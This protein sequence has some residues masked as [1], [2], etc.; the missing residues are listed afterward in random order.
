M[1][2]Y[3]LFAGVFSH[4]AVKGAL[5]DEAWLQALLDVEAGLARA[6]ARAGLA[7]PDAAEAVG[8]AAL[9]RNFSLAELGAAS[10]QAGNPIPALVKALRAA[11][12]ESARGA[13]HTGATSQDIVDSALM[14][15][16]RRAG[17]FVSRDLE[18]AAAAAAQLADRH[19]KT[20]MLGRTLLQQAVPITF[21]FKAAGWL[22]G[23]DRAS[24]GWSAALEQRAWLQFG[25][26][27]GTLAVLG[28]RA[29]E[30]AALLAAEL[31]LREAPLPWHTERTPILELAA[32][33]AAVSAVSGKIARDSTLL[34][35]SEVAEVHEARAPGRGGS[36]TMPH[37]QNPVA[38]VAVL[39]CTRRVPGLLAT[40]FAA[41]EQE[42]ERAAG[43]WHAEWEPFSELLRL[44][45]SASAWLAE[46]LPNLHVDAERMRRNLDAAAGFPF[47]ENLNRL[48]APALGTQG[49][50]EFVE[51]AI[52][53]AQAAGRTLQ[54]ALLHEPDLS[55]A[56]AQAG[57]D[58]ARL[59][60][61]F[62]PLL[63][64]GS[65]ERWIERALAL[66]AASSRP[67][68]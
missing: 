50:S 11:V 30:V 46:L 45:A 32:A 7:A 37:K 52:E 67:N 58:P 49:A 1:T 39:S 21:G 15:L 26:A 47:A 61:V 17:A 38:S 51:R 25:G 12:P 65:C 2:G 5:S 36:S 13:V 41:A 8:R 24:A 35:Q 23:L 48:L 16:A 28:D 57:F 29:A 60:D 3:E 54:D 44:S 27:A 56:L 22:C 55:G 18:A 43:A 9:A 64:L 34:A 66:H 4:G 10:A 59:R 6:L 33:L 14:L 42:H 40:L 20:P 63:Y 53:R 62:D 31:G 68:V 19:R